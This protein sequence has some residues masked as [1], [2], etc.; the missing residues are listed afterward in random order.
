MYY[1]ILPD[2]LTDNRPEFIPELPPHGSPR[3]GEVVIFYENGELRLPLQVNE[4]Y[5]VA[6]NIYVGFEFRRGDEF[7]LTQEAA[8]VF[9]KLTRE[10][11]VARNGFDENVAPRALFGEPLEYISRNARLKTTEIFVRDD[12]FFLA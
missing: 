7:G 12:F 9:C 1:P 3:F 10:F 8:I 4:R 11:R 6:V 2:M 5:F